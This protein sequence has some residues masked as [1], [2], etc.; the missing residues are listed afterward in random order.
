MLLFDAPEQTRRERVVGRGRVSG[1]VEDNARDFRVRN[2][3][4]ARL[5]SAAVGMFEER[6]LLVKVKWRLG[7]FD[8]VVTDVE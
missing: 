8:G 3:R 5:S 2:E 4:F 7:G 6:G 1:R